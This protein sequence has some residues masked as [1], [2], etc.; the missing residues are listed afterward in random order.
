MLD[1]VFGNLLR[2]LPSTG[3]L[4]MFVWFVGKQFNLAIDMLKEHLTQLNRMIETC[5]EE[6]DSA[7]HNMIAAMELLLKDRA[8]E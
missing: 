1:E 2:D 6:K 3:I 5:L 4:V 8:G 7:R